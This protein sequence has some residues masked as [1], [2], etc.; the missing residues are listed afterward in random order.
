LDA[1]EHERIQRRLE[2]DAQLQQQLKRVQQGVV[3]LQWDREPIAPPTGLAVRTCR[4]I[5]EIS[6]AP[7]NPCESP[8]LTPA[9]ELAL[10]PAARREAAVDARFWTLADFVV[11]AGVCLAAACLF[12]PAIVAS[13]Y[14][15]QLNVCKHNL[16]RLGQAVAMYSQG[17]P[18]GLIPVVPASGNAAFAGVYAPK[19]LEAGLISDDTWV[20][21]PARGRSTL[22]VRI[23]TL[24]EIYQA[25]GPELRRFHRVTG[26][27]YAYRIGWVK[28]GR[29]QGIRYGGQENSPLLADNPLDQAPDSCISSHGRGQN[30]L[31]EDCHVSF[32]VTRHRPGTERDD[33]FLNDRWLPQAGEH[34]DDCVL[35]PSPVSPLP[36]IWSAHMTSPGR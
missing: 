10:S 30:V 28:N 36:R 5:G 23:P 7:A 11:A 16:G 3:P 19:L 14:H 26:G 8:D 9:S 34:Q 33:L 25:R 24:N 18:R 29:L 17:E 15:S 31:F 2:Q 1:S 22:V 20:R 12:F 21:C 6:G 35:L 4:M 13:R 27:D 32:L